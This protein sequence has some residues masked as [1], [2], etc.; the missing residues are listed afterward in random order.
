MKKV[1]NLKGMPIIEGSDNLIKKGQLQ[2]KKS[3]NGFTLLKRDGTGSLTSAI[4]AGGSND[5]PGKPSNISSTE[6][7]ISIMEEYQSEADQSGQF[8]YLGFVDINGNL[9]VFNSVEE[10]IT[11]EIPEITIDGEKCLL[12]IHGTTDKVDGLYYNIYSNKEFPTWHSV[13][14]EGKALKILTTALN[15]PLDYSII[16][17]ND[18]NLYCINKEDCPELKIYIGEGR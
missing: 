12:L 17:N 8:N 6:V 18:I 14:A 10:V 13:L 16:Y 11:C 2:Y 3:D 1:G 15:I 7:Q 5:M 4:G 9:S